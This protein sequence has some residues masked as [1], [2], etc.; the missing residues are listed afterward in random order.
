MVLC[1]AGVVG[2]WGIGFFSPELVGDVITKSLKG[3]GLSEA[4]IASQ[5]GYWIGINSIIQ[6]LGAFFGILAFA[7]VAQRIGRRGAFA[8]GFVAAFLMTFTY[9]RY[10]QSMSGVLPVPG[11]L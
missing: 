8:I 6:N 5:K 2:L 7:W 3:Q 4:Q 10:F 9:F 11:G 1:I